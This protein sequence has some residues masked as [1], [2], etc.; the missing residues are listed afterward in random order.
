L[1]IQSSINQYTGINA[2][3]NSYL[4]NAMGAWQSFHATHVVHLRDLLDEQ[5]PPG[6]IA[7]SEQSL[8][9]R[10]TAGGVKPPRSASKQGSSSGF[11]PGER[12][13]A[14]GNTI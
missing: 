10:H 7:D 11:M 2:H 14:A 5:L 9:L 13:S 6:Y 8:Q 3:L 12:F 1:A 4:Q